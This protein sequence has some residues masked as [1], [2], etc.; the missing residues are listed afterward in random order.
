MAATGLPLIVVITT[1]ATDNGY[2][3]SGDAAAMV[4]AGML[5]VV[6]FPALALQLLGRTAKVSVEPGHGL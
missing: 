1:I 2:L 6:I 4:A 3:N 5:S